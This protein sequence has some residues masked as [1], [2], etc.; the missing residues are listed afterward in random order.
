[1]IS[2]VLEIKNCNATDLSNAIYKPKFWEMI[3]PVTKIEAEFIAPNVLQTDIV[4]EINLAIKI[5]IKMHGELVLNDKGEQ[6]PQGK[7]IEFNVRNNKDVKELEGNIRIK[8]LSPQETKVGVFIH[9]FTLGSD[10]LKL[11]GK[12]ADI[13]LQTK[14]TNMLRKLETYCLSQRLKDLP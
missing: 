3:S 1:M 11:F 9:S 13:V 4:D 8:Q 12:F 14:I 5:P 10:F 6:G 7:L 2:K